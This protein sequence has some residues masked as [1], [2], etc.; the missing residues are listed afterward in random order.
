MVKLK[1]V[2][3]TNYF[4]KDHYGYYSASLNDKTHPETGFIVITL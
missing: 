1:N 4:H 2:I 3:M